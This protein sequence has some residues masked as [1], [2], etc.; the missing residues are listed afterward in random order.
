MDTP[1]PLATATRTDTMITVAEDGPSSSTSSPTTLDRSTTP[2]SLSRSTTIQ[3]IDTRPRMDGGAKAWLVVLGSFLIHSFCFA[4][5][6]TVFGIF[7]LHY[8]DIFPRATASSIAFV[9]TVGSAVTYL[10]GFV[11]GIVA[12][13]FG[14]R[15]TALFGTFLMTSSLVLSSFATQL[16]HLFLTQGILFGVGAS[17]TYYPAVAAP[18]HWFANKRGLATGLA[19]SGVGAGG[20]VL[21]PLTHW[22]I[23]RLDIQWTLRTLGLFCL[24]L[25]GTASCLISERKDLP[26]YESVPQEGSTEEEQEG[27]EMSS[28]V[29]KLGKKTDLSAAEEA[30]QLQ[31][32]AKPSFFESLKVFRD[33]QFLALTMAELAASIGYL[34]PLYYMQTYAVF[35][36]LTPQRGAMILG[37][38][39]GASFTGRIGLGI[40]SDYI[41]NAKVLLLCAWMT[42]F[43]VTILW[44]FS[45]TFAAFLSMALIFGFFAGGYVSLVPVAVAESF[46]TKQ[47]ASNIGLMYAASGL[48]ILGGSPLAGYLLDSTLHTSYLPVTMTAGA[49]M[50]LGALC[51][52]SWV[53]FRW[54]ALRA[55]KA[56]QAAAEA[57]AH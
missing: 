52:S 20:S 22:L 32:Q 43:A 5:T 25:C 4:P 47:V 27:M 31:A 8:H 1:V 44:T 9:G 3:V 24:V 49:S 46:G 50:T 57:V 30:R 33:P 2:P 16:W 41:S 13:R 48:G 54:R 26:T 45:T 19:V 10:F 51:V 36:G 21:A 29:S 39:N 34:I 23:D 42:A 28:N 40:L 17:L 38:S 53:Y 55:A 35:I 7:E 11:A 56:A 14:F 12:D 6:E 18:S 37:L 15:L